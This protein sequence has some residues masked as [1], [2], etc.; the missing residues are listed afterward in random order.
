MQ[1]PAKVEN[2]PA[3]DVSAALPDGKAALRLK[4]CPNPPMVSWRFCPSNVPVTDPTPWQPAL[5]V[6]LPVMLS[7]DCSKNPENVNCSVLACLTSVI[8]Q[9][10]D[11]GAEAVAEVLPPPH[12]KVAMERHNSK[13]TVNDLNGFSRNGLSQFPVVKRFDGL[14]CYGLIGYGLDLR[15]RSQEM[16]SRFCRI[17]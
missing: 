14:T 3:M 12:D 6:T 2:S 16:G 1:P 11:N 13:A 4:S 9:L 7:P 17:R 5:R 10:P 8:C 15:L